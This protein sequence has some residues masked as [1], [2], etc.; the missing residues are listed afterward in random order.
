MRI[1]TS[2]GHRREYDTLG[3]YM[4]V[5]FFEETQKW[6]SPEEKHAVVGQITEA[7]SRGPEELKAYLNSIRNRCI[8]ARS[9]LSLERIDSLSTADWAFEYLS[10]RDF[11]PALVAVFK[12]LSSRVALRCVQSQQGSGRRMKQHASSRC[13]P[14]PG[15]TRGGPSL[16]SIG[17][18]PKPALCT[19]LSA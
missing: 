10:D 11:A 6:A 1:H 13:R 17:N 16:R 8:F 2:S 4:D 9:A 7:A 19:L 18:W 14:C 15:S 12:C 5:P 3:D